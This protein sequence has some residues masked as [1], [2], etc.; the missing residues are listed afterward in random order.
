MQFKK[1]H[2]ILISSIKIKIKWKILKVYLFLFNTNYLQVFT[3]KNLFHF[4]SVIASNWYFHFQDQLLYIFADNWFRENICF[5]F[6]SRKFNL[7]FEKNKII[8]WRRDFSSHDN[9]TYSAFDKFEKPC[10]KSW[11]WHAVP[12]VLSVSVSRH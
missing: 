6:F 3:A 7:L 10:L 11:S 9:A 8:F 12:F 4:E 1:K 5:I 2:K